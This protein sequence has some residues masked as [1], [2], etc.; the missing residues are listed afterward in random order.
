[1]LNMSSSTS[2][3]FTEKSLTA[4]NCILQTPLLSGVNSSV[5]PL[6]EYPSPSIV[7]CVSRTIRDTAS[8]FLFFTIGY[9]RLND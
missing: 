2:E 5:V 4:K 1:M 6:N 9:V 7:V 8:V 3:Y